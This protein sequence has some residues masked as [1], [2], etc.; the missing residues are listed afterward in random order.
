MKLVQEMREIHIL[1]ASE[2]LPDA[3]PVD[4]SLSVKNG[5]NDDTSR[6]ST[7]TQGTCNSS[8]AGQ[9]TC[10]SDDAGFEALDQ[11]LRQQRNMAPLSPV[12]ERL[13]WQPLLNK[14]EVERQYHK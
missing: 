2:S 11:D 5:G 10:N 13:L 3:T 1:A 14:H 7:I 6:V 4:V 8:S 9:A 12:L